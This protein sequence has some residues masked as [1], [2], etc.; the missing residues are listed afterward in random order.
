V[1]NDGF[2]T[3][4]GSD[5]FDYSARGELT[6]ASVGG[7]SGTYAYD[8]YGRRVARTVGASTWRY[9]YGNPEQEL[10]VTAVIDPAGQLTTIDYTDQGTIFSFARGASRYFVS[11][12]QVGSPRVVTDTAGTVVKAVDYSA[13][14]QLLSDSAPA[15]ELPIGYAG[16]VPDSL[17]GFLHMGLRD[18]DPASGRFTGR[19]PL[20]FGGAQANL[21]AYAANNP[22]ENSDPIGLFSIDLTIC[23]GICVGTKIT[24][25]GD[26]ISACA[27]GGFGVGGVG[28]EVNP[29]GEIDDNKAYLKAAVEAQIGPFA[30]LELSNEVNSDGCRRDSKNQAKVC[31]A[32]AC[33]TPEEGITLTDDMLGLLKGGTKVGVDGKVVGGVCQNAK[34]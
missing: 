27:E 17:T 20:L 12:D 5:T 21:Y 18:Y 19:D 10:Q 22:A 23:E 30:S 6:E 9:L 14:G 8:G 25:T 26:G 1:S 28:V 32:G 13:Y 31:I 15:F 29:L 3:G 4:R 7:Q 2:L 24:I 33:V 34:F 16:G 11:A